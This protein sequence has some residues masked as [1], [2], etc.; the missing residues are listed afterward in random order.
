MLKRL[1]YSVDA[2]QTGQDAVCQFREAKDRSQDYDAILLD[3]RNDQGM[4]GKD[5]LAEILDMD[6]QARAIVF[7][8]YSDDNVVANYAEYGFKDVLLK[9]FSIQEM[10]QKLAKLLQRG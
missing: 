2:V 9:P 5:A 10:S 8:G 4:D 3:L 1:G 6:P 7:S